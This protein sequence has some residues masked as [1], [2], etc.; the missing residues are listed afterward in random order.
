MT[1]YDY[2]DSRVIS[3]LQLSSPAVGHIRARI[4]AEE[5]ATREALDTLRRKLAAHGFSTLM[6]VSDGT[7]SIEVR[8]IRSEDGL[9]TALEKI[10][11]HATSIRKDP[12]KDGYR[13]SGLR[14]QLRNN[15][16][17]LSALFYDL[18]NLALIISGVQRGRHNRGGK[19]TKGD[20]AELLT[21]AAFT[22]GDLLMTA[23]GKEKGDEEL[24]AAS[25]GLSAHLAEK[26]YHIPHSDALTPETLHK[27]GVMQAASEWLHKHIAGVKAT[28]EMTGGA[29]MIRAGM[30]RDQATGKRN[31][32][33]MAAGAMLASSWLIT[34]LLD[35]PRGHTVFDQ[36]TDAIHGNE[37][38][39]ATLMEN[40]RSNPRGWIAAPFSMSNNVFNL[41]GANRERIEGIE[42]IAEASK[43]GN[44]KQLTF[45]K[46]KQHDYIWNVL[47]AG[48]FLVA[49]TLFG[50][51]GMQRP[52]ET[53]AD[54]KAMQDLVLVSANLLS[55]QP[56]PLRDA[57]IDEAADYVTTLA[58]VELDKEAIATQL[59][60]TIQRLGQSTWATRVQSEPDAQHVTQQI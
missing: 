54:K 40:I 1:T 32:F 21:G 37:T 6:H 59:R 25:E 28:T 58:H 33:K 15:P 45:V 9:V 8:G 18:G 22:V 39:P 35:R 30:K 24:R 20:Y 26:G 14:E 60:D 57:L 7:P 41:I 10:G 12:E 16:F 27:T 48:S 49:H 4:I 23:Y 55:Q 36:R 17:F 50:I 3:Q 13:A 11:Y 31:S 53:D 43:S 52:Q 19:F 34:A 42:A 47:T 38:G 5:P 44:A 2:S 51:S 29:F 46:R 56:E